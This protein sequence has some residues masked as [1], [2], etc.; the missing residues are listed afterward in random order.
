MINNLPKIEFI[1][2]RYKRATLKKKASV[3]MRIYYDG[4]QKY[5]S[6]GISLYPYQWKN[7]TVINCPDAIQISQSLDN[8]LKGVRQIIVTM[9]DEGNIDI[10]SIPSRLKKLETNFSSFIDFCKQRA[11][12]RKYGKKRDTQKRYD[13]FL[14]QFESWGLIS[15]FEDVTD[16]N[17]VL[18]DKFLKS[19]GMKPYSKWNNYHR[20]VESFILDAIEEGRLKRNPYKWLN[21]PRQQESLGLDRCL[22]PEEFHRIK[23]A[24]MPTES[25]DRIRDLFIFQTYTCLRYS[26][27][28]KFDTQ[29]IQEIK[30]MPV[31]LSNSIKTDKPFVVPLLSP[32]LDI[33]RKYGGKLPV[34][35][36]TKYNL[37]LKFVAQAAGIDKPLSTHWA[38]HTGAT[39]LLNEGADMKIVT[40]VC[41]HSS[42]RITEKVYAKL[43]TETVV[44]AIKEIKDKLE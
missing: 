17:I 14:S 27:L 6:T 23:T 10:F 29:N 31:Y 36:N 25:L 1:Y 32:T 40:K 44:N 11:I 3:E 28:R 2:D 33:L 16:Q 38:R 37:Y 26:D 15:R 18:Y 43:L 19:K 42:T 8:L 39:M 20:F 34:I 12:I 5:I 21:I 4:K 22:T 24:K 35:S 13:R 41:G 7:N 9:M 30:G